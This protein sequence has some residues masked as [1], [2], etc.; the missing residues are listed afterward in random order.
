MTLVLLFRGNEGLADLLAVSE[1]LYSAIFVS[2]SVNID[3]PLYTTSTPPTTPIFINLVL[4][5]V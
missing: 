4:K 5:M 1:L 3:R 2:K